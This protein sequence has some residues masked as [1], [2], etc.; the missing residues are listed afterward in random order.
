[1]GKDMARP[2]CCWLLVLVLRS[3][4][5]ALLCQRPGE[6]NHFFL[7]WALNLS[8][9]L[10]CSLMLSNR[11]QAQRSGRPAKQQSLRGA[12]AYRQSPYPKSDP[13]LGLGKQKFMCSD[14]PVV[15]EFSYPR[16]RGARSSKVRPG[17][18]SIVSS[19]WLRL[20]AL[21]KKAEA[22]WFS[23]EPSPLSPWRLMGSVAKWHQKGLQVPSPCYRQ[24]THSPFAAFN[25]I[26]VLTEL[27]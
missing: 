26:L 21:L 8:T 7:K 25:A 17:M 6:K 14:G 15:R 12:L 20:E 4:L 10:C 13:V 18:I 27:K 1:M 22:I 5:Q 2:Q 11:E 16:S 23:S 19:I 9:Q 3:I 24:R